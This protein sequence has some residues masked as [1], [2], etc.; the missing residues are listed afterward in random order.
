MIQYTCD[1]CGRVISGQR[2]AI[3]IEIRRVSDTEAQLTTADL[4]QDN[5]QQIADEISL[6]D[7]TVEFKLPEP[8]TKSVKLDL[9]TGCT[10]RFEKD[11]LSRDTH[12]R[13]N[14]SPN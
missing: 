10:R 12:K 8:I 6:M 11:P 1:Q 2:Y 13:F 14:I 9:C 7:S 4:D 5:L 3:Q